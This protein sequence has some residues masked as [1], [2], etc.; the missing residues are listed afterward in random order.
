MIQKV[1]A[2][3]FL[4]GSLERCTSSF[5]NSVAEAFVAEH[6][7]LH[8]ILLLPWGAPTTPAEHGSPLL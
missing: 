5:E 7:A 4:V 3:D 1:H 2:A 6:R 8:S